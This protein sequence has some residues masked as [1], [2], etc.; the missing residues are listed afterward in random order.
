MVQSAHPSAAAILRAV[1]IIACSVVYVSDVYTTSQL[2]DDR[3]LLQCSPTARLASTQNGLK[4]IFHR[5]LPTF[6][7]FVGVAFGVGFGC[8]V[9]VVMFAL[10]CVDCALE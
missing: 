1:F 5:L 6:G 7:L 2:P 3:M 10:V 8:L 9:F 4:L